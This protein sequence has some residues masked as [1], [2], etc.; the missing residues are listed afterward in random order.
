MGR[1]VIVAVAIVVLFGMAFFAFNETGFFTV[2]NEQ[3][4]IKVAWVGPL[5]GNY[6][7]FGGQNM[8]GV[9]LAVEKI[10]AEGGINGKQIEL[11]V[12]DT[13]ADQK[14]F[15]SAVQKLSTVDNVN[16]ILTSQY[17][18]LFAARGIA[19]RNNFVMINAIDASG[20]LAEQGDNI[21]GI[22]I[23]DEGIGFSLAEFAVKEA[24]HKRVGIVFLN[25][26]AIYTL[27]KSSFK[28]RFEELGGRIVFEEGYSADE[29]DFRTIVEKVKSQDI[30][31]LFILNFDEGGFLLRQ[32]RELGFEKPF[33][34]IDVFSS[35]QFLDNAGTAV[36]GAAFTFWTPPEN[37]EYRAFSQAFEEK[38]G[39]ELVEPLFASTGFDAM[40]AV[41]LAI[42]R[43]GTSTAGIKKGLLGIKDM[44]GLTGSLTMSQDGIVRTVEEKIF[45]MG[46]DGSFRP[47]E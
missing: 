16:V 5:S 39:K 40:N 30:D 2:N 44:Q 22:G 33:L 6:A 19:E 41:A 11:I 29:S 43:G 24:G 14:Q 26:E 37:P 27:F 31:A 1:T 20:E 47:F 32:A 12:E 21:F 23:Y 13:Q 46:A 36:E 45:I 38:Y 18:E 17:T 8:R 9:E 4:T 15:L 42:E 34:G 35:Q 3:S 10:N 28:E 25:S 7:S